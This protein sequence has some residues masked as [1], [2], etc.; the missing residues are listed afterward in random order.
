VSIVVIENGTF[1]PGD[2]PAADTIV[3]LLVRATRAIESHERVE[4]ERKQAL[5]VLSLAGTPFAVSEPS[6]AEVRLSEAAQRLLANVVDADD[7]LRRLLALPATPGAS[8]QVEVEL[9][10]G[11]TEHLRGRISPVDDDG[12][13]VALLELE[14]PQPGIAPAVLGALTP[15]EQEVAVQVAEGLADREIAD[16]LCLSHHTV[17]QYVKRIYRK[18]GVGSRVALTRVVLGT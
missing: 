4:R 7:S 9:T 8:R 11:E 3:R 13:V 17:S 12:T 2:I 16:R 10:S 5:A 18:L 15:R 1:T 6:A 14:R